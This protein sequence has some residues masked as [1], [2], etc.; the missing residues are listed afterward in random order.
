MKKILF[1]LIISAL[2][3]FFTKA[4]SNS[5]GTV[6]A[7]K[8]IYGEFGGS[9]LI[10]SANFDSR[11]KGHNGAGFRVGIGG[12]GG[13]GGGILT[14]PFGLNYLLGKEGPHYF[15]FGATATLVT[16]AFNVGDN[17]GSAWFFIPHLGYR[18]SKASKSFNGRIYV[19]PL[20]TSAFVFFPFGGLS[21]GY[22][23]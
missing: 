18:F 14:F 2:F 20:I 23:L 10:F 19:A 12:A 22:T 13:T 3:S 6:P 5:A 1:L 17:K 4:Q 21:V 15:E 8:A 16:A 7:S 9:G 11:F